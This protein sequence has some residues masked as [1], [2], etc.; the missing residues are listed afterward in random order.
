MRCERLDLRARQDFLTHV[1]ADDWR[2]R[3]TTVRN[4]KV[5]VRRTRNCANNGKA[6]NGHRPKAEGEPI[7]DSVARSGE[8]GGN[9]FQNARAMRRAL[10]CVGKIHDVSEELTVHRY[11]RRL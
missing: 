3:Y 5:H 11:I 2:Q 8:D 10:R 4:R 7:Q 9:S 6:V 1:S